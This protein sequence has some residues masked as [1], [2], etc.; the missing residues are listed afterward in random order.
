[1]DK[2]AGNAAAVEEKTAG[3]MGSLDS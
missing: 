2:Q 1:M 3:I